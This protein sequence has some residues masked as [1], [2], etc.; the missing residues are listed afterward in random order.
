MK[1]TPGLTIVT[2]ALQPVND[3]MS[4]VQQTVSRVN[5]VTSRRIGHVSLTSRMVTSF[6]AV[7][8]SS[9]SRHASL[10]CAVARG[11]AWRGVLGDGT[12]KVNVSELDAV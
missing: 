1:L 4:A 2:E 3:V 11:V 5:C 10:R 8:T 9:I 6:I 12:L 7:M